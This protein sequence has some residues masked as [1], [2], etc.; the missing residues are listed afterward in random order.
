VDKLGFFCFLPLD[1]KT[2]NQ[3]QSKVFKLELRK[4][5]VCKLQHIEVHDSESHRPGVL[6]NTKKMKRKH[7]GVVS[8][9][10][11]KEYKVVFKNP[12]LMDN[13]DN[14]IWV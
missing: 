5:N 10:G 14:A 13:F 2:Y 8:E 7:G 6:N 12:R 3:I 9:T 1:R 11:T 4:F